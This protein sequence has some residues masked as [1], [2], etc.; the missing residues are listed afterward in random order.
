[1]ASLL[2]RYRNLS[3]LLLV[4]FAQLILVAYQV[5]TGQ[6]VRLI[7]VWAVSAVTPLARVLESVSA[8][9]SHLLE[10]YVVLTGA[11]QENRRMVTELDKLKL[12]NRS[13]RSELRTAERAQALSQFRARIPSQ[14]LA[15][16]VI[17]TGTGVNSRSVFVDRGSL[18][19]VKAGMAVITADGLVGKVTAAYPASAQVLLVTDP[20][21]AAGVLNAQ[22]RAEGTLKGVS[23]TACRVDYLQ[24]EEKV[25]VGEWFYTSGED[26]I[27]PRGLPVG[28]VQAV[29]V[30][31]P[32]KEVILKPSGLARGLEEVLIVL[33]GV[34]EQIPA[35][36]AASD[37][38]PLLPPP[39]ATQPTGAQE[40]GVS[41]AVPGTDA[42]RLV[43]RYR[44]AAE[45]EGRTY[46]DR[47]PIPAPV[48]P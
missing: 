48:K 15:A 14:T 6:D 36:P 10:D 38:A 31:Q 16:R 39:A 47:P 3:F 34:H 43:E 18:S 41:A 11:R 21:F 28:Q 46:G 5:K 35:A 2:I 19:G 17:G 4:L 8:N 24:N 30:G 32:F 27:F 26:R 42:D 37:V 29:A 22:S 45:A 40:Q 23:R 25:E 33:A 7:R 13:L 20:N 1:M 12:E 9:V 44:K